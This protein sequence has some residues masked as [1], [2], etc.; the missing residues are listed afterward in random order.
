ML[1]FI[2]QFTSFANSLTPKQQRNRDQKRL[3]DKIVCPIRVIQS[4]FTPNP[5]S[6]SISSYLKASLILM[7]LLYVCS[8]YKGQKTSCLKHNRKANISVSKGKVSRDSEICVVTQHTVGTQLCFMTHCITRVL[9]FRQG[10]NTNY[11]PG[12]QQRSNMDE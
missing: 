9:L 7:P 2:L 1:E 3:Q 6:L 5:H 10:F 4:S 8:K 12:F 11:P